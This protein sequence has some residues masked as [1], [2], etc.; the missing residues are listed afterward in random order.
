MMCQVSSPICWRDKESYHIVN[1]P[2]FEVEDLFYQ[3]KKQDQYVHIPTWGMRPFYV[4]FYTY[5]TKEN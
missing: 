2:P 1:D 5:G 4:D 3:Q